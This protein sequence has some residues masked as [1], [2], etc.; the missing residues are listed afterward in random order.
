M[1]V[2]PKEVVTY[3]G[4]TEENLKEFADLD[5]FKEDADKRFI[6]RENAVK[7]K[8]FLKQ[9][10]GKVLGAIQTKFQ[11]TAKGFGIEFKPEE[12]KDATPEKLFE[13]SLTK[14]TNASTTAQEELKKQIGAPPDARVKEWEEK[15]NTLNTKY[16]DTE[17]LLSST[18]EA[19]TSFKNQTQSEIKNAKLSFQTEQEYGKIEA[20]FKPGIN[21]V[22]KLGFRS[23]VSTKAKFDFGDDGKLIVTDLEGHLIPSKAK[24][25]EFQKPEEFLKELGLQL[26]VIPVNPHANKQ[27][28]KAYVP[29]T[30]PQNTNGNGNGTEQPVRK[31]NPF[32]PKVNTVRPS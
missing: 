13:L 27:I 16:S 4:Y 23:A 20:M 2:D 21:E 11:S 15:Y 24:H 17:K 32:T 26:G 10:T 30:S 29:Q 22:E 3:L 9:A 18:N 1:A 31:I 12:I 25:G 28:P 6:S 14:L 19:F 8:D 7:D 5:A